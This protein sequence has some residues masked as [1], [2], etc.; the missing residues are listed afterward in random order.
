MPVIGCSIKSIV[1]ERKT[2]AA[3]NMNINSTPRI[4]TVEEKELD[5]LGKQPSLLIGFEFESSYNP[6]VAKIKFIGELIYATKNSKEILKTWK[7]D[8]RLSEDAD[9]EIKNFLFKKCLTLGV[10]LSEELE[11]PPPVVFPV[12]LPQRKEEQPK[13]IG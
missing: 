5:L 8:G 9:R 11:L 1:A 3:E 13:Y 7:K 2:T 12:I 6:D 10:N 4:T